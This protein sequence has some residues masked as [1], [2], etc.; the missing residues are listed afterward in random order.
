MATLIDE[1][2]EPAVDEE[3]VDLPETLP[4]Q[5]PPVEPLAEQQDT[6]PE[7][8]LPD[9]YKGKSVVDIV[10][11][12]QEAEKVIGKQGQEVGELRK[13]VDSYIQTQL[14]PR[15]DETEK[16]EE[17]DFFA[18]PDKAVAQAIEKHPAIRQA[19]EATQQNQKQ[20]TLAR[21]QQSHPD[22][23]EI[24]SDEKFGEWVSASPVRKKLL[25]QADNEYDFDSA[26]ELFTLWKERQSIAQQTQQV[27]TQARQQAVRQASTGGAQG[28]AE[29]RARKKYRRADI[30]KLIQTDPERY[31]ALQP[32]IMA[33]Y[34]EGRVI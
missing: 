33:A 22:M 7:D 21:L 1:S 5:D 10:R 28:S 4:E 25:V 27:E 16:P 31:E 13:V 9:K 2:V 14:S 20:S 12:H 26:N 8:T 30:I 19:R 15:Q 23:P 11:M 32:E 6:P 18:D 24:L 34:K 29:P 17:V 3:T